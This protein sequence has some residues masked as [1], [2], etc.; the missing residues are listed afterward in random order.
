MYM[1]VSPLVCVLRLKDPN[2]NSF[3]MYHKIRTTHLNSQLQ[4]VYNS[5]LPLASPVPEG[6]WTSTHSTASVS[7][8]L[9]MSSCSQAGWSPPATWSHQGYPGF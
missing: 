2:I 8:I 9:G 7:A 4:F 3:T 5:D 1:Y 6:P